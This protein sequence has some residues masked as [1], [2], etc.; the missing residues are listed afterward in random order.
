MRESDAGQSKTSQSGRVGVSSCEHKAYD[1]LAPDP[2]L[3]VCVTV[4][5]SEDCPDDDFDY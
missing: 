2:R 4:D 1:C 5:V 3:A